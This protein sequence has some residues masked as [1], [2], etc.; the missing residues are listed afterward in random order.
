M[1]KLLGIVLVGMFDWMLV[2]HIRN[3]KFMWGLVISLLLVDAV[4]Q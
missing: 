1:L 2:K 3:A 4:V